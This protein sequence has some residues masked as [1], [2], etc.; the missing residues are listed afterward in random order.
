MIGQ[1]QKP[2][3]EVLAM[4]NG[5]QK[6]VLCACGGCATVFRTGDEPEVKE[7]ADILSHHGKRVLAAIA[8]PFGEFTC[9]APGS[10]TGLSKY[11][12][13]ILV[14]SYSGKSLI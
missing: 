9:Y 10:I 1:V 4:L 14:S 3:D 8:P 11:R 12:Q 13:E 2:I 6:L 5:K 7:M